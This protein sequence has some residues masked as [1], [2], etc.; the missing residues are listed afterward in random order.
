MD[1]R[2]RL[3]RLDPLARKPADAGAAA[4]PVGGGEAGAEAAARLVAA[5]G[6]QAEPAVAGAVWTRED[7]RSEVPC[8]AWP[9]PD[10]T[11]ILPVATPP[12]RGWQDVLCLDTETTGLAGGTGTVVFLIG[13]GWWQDD[14]FTVRQLFLPGPHLE[15]PLLRTLSALAGRFRVLVTYNGG[16]F[17]LPLLRTR[18]L[19]NRQPDP[20]GHLASWDLLGAARRLWGRSLP[21]C[22]QQTVEARVCRYRRG[23]GDIDGALIPGVYQ[24]FL[25]ET[26]TALLDAVLRHNR[27]DIAGL[28]LMLGAVAAA[29]GGIDAGPERWHGPPAEAWGRALI[30]ERRGHREL[31]AA[32]ARTAVKAGI[33]D[34]VC[35]DGTLPLPGWLDAIRL[36]KRVADWPLVALLVERGLVRWP[37][38]PRLLYEAAVLYE[39]RLGDLQRALAYARALADARREQRLLARLAR[40]NL[41]GTPAPGGCEDGQG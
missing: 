22:R 41:M 40:V 26:E 28:G 11:Q 1:L 15:A 30:C 21:D 24:A 37:A 18:A 32:W 19:L 13:L 20:C 4:V 8:P 36:L 34:A 35:P 29:A 3:A 2:R 39:H 7:V 16:T 10:L 33:A 9:P 17:D 12:P 31:A 14:R 27:R 6:L 38:Q 23:P 5:L 25:R